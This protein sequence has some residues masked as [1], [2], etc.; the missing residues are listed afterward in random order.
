VPIVQ[1][2]EIRYCRYE[3]LVIRTIDQKSNIVA[4]RE[5]RLSPLPCLLIQIQRSEVST[6]NVKNCWLQTLG[7]GARNCAAPRS[8]SARAIRWPNSSGFARLPWSETETRAR[9]SCSI[10]SASSASV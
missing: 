7:P 9:P 2:D 10:T 1:S 8:R 6:D 5:N 4:H 3:T